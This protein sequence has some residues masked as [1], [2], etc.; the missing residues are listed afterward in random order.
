[1]WVP[2]AENTEQ[3]KLISAF[4]KENQVQN[5]DKYKVRVI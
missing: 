3:G 1:M 2:L 5:N 4:L